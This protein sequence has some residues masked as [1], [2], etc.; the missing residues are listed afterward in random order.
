MELEELLSKMTTEGIIHG[1]S[2]VYRA[3]TALSAETRRLLLN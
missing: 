3:M 1:D 2:E